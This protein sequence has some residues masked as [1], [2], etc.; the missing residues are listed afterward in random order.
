[1]DRAL[2][3]GG[4][5]RR[6]E[7]CRARFLP[8]GQRPGYLAGLRVLA[9]SSLR[10]SRASLRAAGA[11]A[12]VLASGLILLYARYDWTGPSR[13]AERGFWLSAYL[14]L[15]LLPTAY[16]GARRLLHSTWAARAVAA[17]IFVVT[18]LPWELL[19]LD[20]FAYYRN[21]PLWL[22][23]DQTPNPP[24]HE[25]FPGGTLRAFPYDWAFMPLL[26][27]T[28]C[29]LIWGAWSIR[30]RVL[31]T[32]AA[33]LPLLLTVAFALIC[34]QGYL[35]SSMRAPYTYDPYFASPKKMHRWYGVAH[36]RDGSGVTNADEFVFI[37]LEQYFQG[38]AQEGDNQL[39]RRPFAFYLASQGSYFI[40]TFYVW[41]GLNCLF[42]LA[43]VLATGRLTALFAGER[44]GIIAGAL[45]TFGP[46]FVAFAA[47]PAMY[48]QGFAAAAI[49]IW[50]FEEL[51]VRSR[52]DRASVALFTGVLTLCSLTYDL[53]PV[54]LAL[55]AYGLARHV[56]PL[57]L[58][59][60]VGG[61]F[62][63][64]RAFGLLVTTGLGIDVVPTNNKQISMSVSN[65][66]DF[67]L[68]PSLGAWSDAAIDVPFNFIKMMLMAFFVVPLVIAVVAFPSVRDR[69]LK[70]LAGTLLAGYFVMNA[71]FLI[72]KP[73]A[74]LGHF[75]RL[76]YFVFP[77]VYLLAAMA[78]TRAE[79]PER[80]SGRLG[81]VEIALR[82]HGAWIV[83]GVMAV[84]VNMDLFGHITPYVE[85]FSGHPP[86]HLP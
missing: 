3:S 41:L 7:S 82:Q 21:R 70:V 24:A 19:G 79:R 66:I 22:Y 75:P 57:I 29:G 47:T 37:P 12:I 51:I 84:L 68:T 1:M 60:S 43:A 38:V 55:I 61:A 53:L 83:V 17:A 77:V 34:A 2:P 67:L 8:T 62:V 76:L 69:P 59:L 72:G 74:D 33:K 9:H 15:I 78:L 36:F 11:W 35:H 65:T 73:Y 39:I 81:S 25:F 71:I 45:T 46:G 6:F 16:Y 13:Y 30:K 14:L 18:T 20:R 63:A 23:L 28:G 44:A 42:W 54:L 32:A 10:T 27:A 52:R 64:S 4:R 86:A 85:F 50:A 49:A 40:N 80:V 48:L 31:R 56:K 5:S 26:F 58:A